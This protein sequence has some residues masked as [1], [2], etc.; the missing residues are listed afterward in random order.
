MNWE[1]LIKFFDEANQLKKIKRAGWVVDKVENP[2]TVAEHTF[3]TALM[4]MFLGRGRKLDMEKV[5]KM[6]II[7]DLAEAK[8]GDI[9]TYHGYEKAFPK[10]EKLKNEEI[11]FHEMVSKIENGEEIFD[12]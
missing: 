7:H 4:C 8:I 5:M 1:E 2:E 12:I 3:G 6:A 9:I 10:E 11:A